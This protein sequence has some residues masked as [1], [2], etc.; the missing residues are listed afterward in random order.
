LFQ[1]LAFGLIS[2]Y[3]RLL[4]ELDTRWFGWLMLDASRLGICDRHGYMLAP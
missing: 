2:I 3:F 1:F 4:E